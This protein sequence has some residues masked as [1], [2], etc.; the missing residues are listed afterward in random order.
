MHNDNIVGLDG[1]VI[2][3]GDETTKSLGAIYS[4]NI[5]ATV[6]F[7]MVGDK[8]QGRFLRYQAR[9]LSLMARGLMANA[10]LSSCIWFFAYFIAPNPEQVAR[11]VAMVW[12]Q[13]GVR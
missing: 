10:C 9:H 8:I 3:H 4:Q 7:E 11:F 13:Y 5:P 12:G 1:I 2:L 6:R